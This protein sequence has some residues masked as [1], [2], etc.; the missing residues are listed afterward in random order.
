[1]GSSPMARIVFGLY[2]EMEVEEGDKN[3]FR[4]PWIDEECWE[5]DL[6]EE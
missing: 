1:M 5:E 4:I 2:R 3:Y 6:I